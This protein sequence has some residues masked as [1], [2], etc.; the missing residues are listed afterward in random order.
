[1]NALKKAKAFL[2]RREGER[3]QVIVLAAFLLVVILVIAGLGIDLGL[4]GVFNI[5]AHNSASV[6]CIAAAEAY[7]RGGSPTAAFASIMQ[8]NGIAPQD[9]SPNQG[10]R[11]ALTRGL[12][13]QGD[14]SWRAAVTWQQPTT[15]FLSG[16][17]GIHEYTVLGKARCVGRDSGGLTPIAVRESAVE[18][19]LSGVP[20]TDYTILG[21]DPSWDLADI[22]SGTNFRGA[23]FVHMWCIPSGDP[24]C[25]NIRYF[26]PLTEAPPS[27]QTQ[28]RLVE[29]CFKGIN[30]SIWPD[31]SER[32]PIVSGTS[33]NQLCHAFQ[34]G[35]WEVGD[36][37]VV[38]V[39]DGTVYSPDP[40]YGNWE[41][42]AVVG[43]A[44]YEIVSFEP[45]PHNCNH[46]LA[47]L[48]G[49]IYESLDEI[50]VDVILLRSREIP[51]DYTG[52]IPW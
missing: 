14:G 28:K 22:E 44:V 15:G 24:N 39:F 35:G 30:C 41:N 51:W 9:Y 32:L 3:G 13:N 5:R 18:D 11:L 52:A 36:K 46:V 1:M 33:D 47:R 34:D 26:Y 31:V 48:T 20:P 16:L 8:A 42:V 50:P 27:A 7:R 12:E 43:Y 17:A 37:I 4:A 19:S 10:T 29:D 40:T 25:P 38:I 21:R 45:N 2:L 6:G 23:V 49:G